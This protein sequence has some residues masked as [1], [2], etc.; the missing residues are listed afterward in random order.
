MFR[1]SSSGEARRSNLPYVYEIYYY[2]KNNN[3]VGNYT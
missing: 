1:I 2:L 3:V